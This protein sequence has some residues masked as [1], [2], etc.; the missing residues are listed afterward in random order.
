MET[1]R[2]DITDSS[3][4]RV[5]NEFGGRYTYKT[6]F[7]VR[8]FARK[9]YKDVELKELKDLV[10]KEGIIA[11]FERGHLIIKDERVREILGLEPLGLYNLDEE[12]MEKLLQSKNLKEIETFLQ[13]T[14]DDNLEKFLRV[15]VQLPV[16]DLDTANL[17]QAYTG[18]NV[19]Q[20]IRDREEEKVQTTG[21]RQRVDGKA[22]ENPTTPVRGRIVPKN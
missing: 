12:R 13:Y 3:M 2:P 7:V 15:A 22:P 16:K 21:V 11:P 8:R 18:R 5:Y 6:E 4:V 17:I 19:I 9:G 1:K 20:I 14:S 10:F